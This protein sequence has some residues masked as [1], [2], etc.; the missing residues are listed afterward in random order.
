MPGNALA[1]PLRSMPGNALALPLHSMPGNALALP[2][3]VGALYE[4][5]WTTQRVLLS[6]Q[7]RGGPFITFSFSVTACSLFQFSVLVTW[8]VNSCCL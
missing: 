8:Y 3:N 7:L 5:P 2:C 4:N 1:L 6:L